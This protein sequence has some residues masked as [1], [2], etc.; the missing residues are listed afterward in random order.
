MIK[1]RTVKDKLCTEKCKLTVMYHFKELF[2]REKSFHPSETSSWA[3]FW[4]NGVFHLVQ[5]NHLHENRF[6]PPRW[7]LTSTLIRSHLGAAYMQWHIS[8]RWDVSAEWDTFH[9]TFKWE[10]Y[11]TWVKYLTWFSSQLA[12]LSCFK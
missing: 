12:C 2:I 6:T 10:W 11:R 7:D 3:R 4:Y 8:P 5:T 1:T 9:T